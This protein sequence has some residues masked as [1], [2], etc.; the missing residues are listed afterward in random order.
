MTGKSE[1]N[2]KSELRNKKTKTEEGDLKIKLILWW[3]Y[4]F[5]QISFTH[6]APWAHSVWTDI[7]LNKLLPSAA[8][9]WLSHEL[10]VS[11]NFVKC[12]SYKFCL[13]IQ[14]NKDIDFFS[15]KIFIALNNQHDLLSPRIR[16]NN[17]Q[18]SPYSTGKKNKKW[19][20]SHSIKA[21]YDTVS[22][23]IVSVRS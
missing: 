1:W 12:S 2:T 11:A 6:E 18:Q 9:F 13:T 20:S 23:T 16:K 10:C 8:S 21:G 15:L 7:N 5:V 17:F 22:E 3:S 14:K 19:N 4:C